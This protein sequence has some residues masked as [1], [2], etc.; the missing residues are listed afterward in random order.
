MP[1]ANSL[2]ELAMNI[3]EGHDRSSP[4]GSGDSALMSTTSS[5][6]NVTSSV[7]QTV[8]SPEAVSDSQSAPKSEF[9]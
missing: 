9:Q 3:R 4:T 7:S 6:T 1:D 8:A 5:T 2:A